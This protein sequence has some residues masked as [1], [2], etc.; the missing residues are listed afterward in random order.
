MR[1]STPRDRKA[2]ASG[3]A[4][5]ALE[6]G[7]CPPRRSPRRSSPARMS[8]LKEE[9]VAASKKSLRGPEA[10]NTRGAKDEA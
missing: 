1:C 2:P 4:I 8:A 5:N 10:T 3:R 6:M 7:V 9:R